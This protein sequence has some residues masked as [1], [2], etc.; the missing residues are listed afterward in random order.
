MKS[1][2]YYYNDC[3]CLTYCMSFWSLF[4]FILTVTFVL[5]WI[6]TPYGDDNND[7][8]FVKSVIFGWCMIGVVA[9]TMI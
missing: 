9:S 5:F 7:K 3:N 2:G 6:F 4:L 8:M 1:R